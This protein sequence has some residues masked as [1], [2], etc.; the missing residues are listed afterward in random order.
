MPVQVEA[1][2]LQ[3]LSENRTENNTVYLNADGSKSLVHSPSATSY[4]ENGQWKDVDSSLAQDSTTGKWETKANSW[5]ARF[6]TTSEGVEVT[7][8]T[9]T[10]KMVPQG[11]NL[12]SPTVT[13]TAP[14][15]IVTYRNAWQGI[16]L[17]YVVDG[18]NL[19]ETI[20]IKSR[21]AASTFNFAV[22]GA[23]LA[24]GASAGSFTL[25]GSLRTP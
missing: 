2:Q 1:Q 19:T 3:K 7:K 24:P 12:T 13:D 4:Q 5:K 16:D 25:D 9:Q 23:K 21:A 11:A 6:G 22:S 14:H 18:S 17:Q 8:D 10:F 15:Q 20:V